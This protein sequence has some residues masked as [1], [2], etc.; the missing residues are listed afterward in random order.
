MKR[1]RTPA[2]LPAILA[3]LVAVLAVAQGAR[4]EIIP[5]SAGVSG[6][7]P[8]TFSYT[9][10]VLGGSQ[11][12]TGD[13]AVLYDVKGYVPGSATAPAGWS[14]SWQNLGPD[15]KQT[16]PNDNPLLPNIIWTYTGASV[17][18]PGPSTVQIPGFSYMSTDGLIGQADFAS[19]THEDPDPQHPK[20]R[21]VSNVTQVDVPAPNGDGGPPPTDSPE[22][23]TVVL[24]FF[25]LAG[26]GL[27]ALRKWKASKTV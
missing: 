1:L 10:G 18:S 23:G 7:G 5:S 24:S 8:F 2:R 20:G 9:F 4:A 12:Q 15:P 3:A 22:P 27:G 19:Q 6:T 13:F 14:V 16:A 17:I 26:L 21:S 11:L 25:G